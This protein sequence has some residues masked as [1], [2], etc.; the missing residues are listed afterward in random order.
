MAATRSQAPA[1]QPQT[2]PTKGGG[3]VTRTKTQ[4]APIRY[5]LFAYNIICFIAWATCT[6]RMAMLVPLLA[7][8]GHLPAIFTHIFSPLLTVTQSLALLEVLHSLQGIVRAP[9]FTTLLQVASR[10]MV[11]WGV[12]FMFHE[13]SG[14]VQPGEGIVGGDYG[15][16]LEGKSSL[17]GVG[18]GAK[19]GD[20]AFLGCLTAWGIT[21][22]IRYG[23]FAL[24]S[25]GRPVPKWWTWL[26]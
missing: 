7:P 17:T 11:V 12:L 14:F 15:R 21:E 24:Q 3:A 26:R 5:Y 19:L 9:V 23:F 20:Y 16:V 1:L 4:S 22:C 2:Q 10:I 6:L 25:W 18:P 13:G 8:N